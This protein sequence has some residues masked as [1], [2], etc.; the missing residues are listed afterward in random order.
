VGAVLDPAQF[1]FIN[2]DLTVVLP[3]DPAGEWLL[4]EAAT[5][6]S[7]QGTGMAE[8]ALSDVSGRCGTAL[9]TL[10]VAPR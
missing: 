7:T 1:I 6:T 10:L 8:T 3:R 2:V 4:L 5:T 9:Q